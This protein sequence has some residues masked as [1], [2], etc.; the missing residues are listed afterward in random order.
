MNHD[1]FP[2]N[3]E[4]DDSA[5]EITHTSRILQLGANVVDR[6]YVSPSKSVES[7]EATGAT[8]GSSGIIRDN[9]GDK[10]IF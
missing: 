8:K 3:K 7:V 6:L 5:E 1:K 2:K 4:S 9:G 10:Q